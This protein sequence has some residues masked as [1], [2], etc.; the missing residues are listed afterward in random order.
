MEE[1][2]IPGLNLSWTSSNG[3]GDSRAIGLADTQTAEALQP[4]HRMLTGSVGKTFTATSMLALLDRFQISLDTPISN[5]FSA[6]PWYQNWGPEASRITIRMLLNHTSGIPDHRA[7]PLFIE[8]LN[9][10]LKQPTPNYSVYFSPEDLIG[11]N[12]D[13]G[14]DFS[15]GSGYSYTETGFIVAGLLIELLAGEPFYALVQHLFIEPLKLTNTTPA[16]WGREYKLAQG[17][18]DPKQSPFPKFTLNKGKLTINPATE[19]TGGGFISTATDLARWGGALYRGEALNAPY[20][21]PMITSCFQGD[22][23]SQYGLG[24]Y[25]WPSQFGT[26]YGHSGEA[27]GYRSIMAY[28]PSLEISLAIQINTSVPDHAI[29]NTLLETALDTIVS[30]SCPQ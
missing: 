24:C 12:D 10:T 5:W 22:P 1:Q 18:V 2:Q 13:Q 3:V 20:L 14:L 29:L 25:L 21:A 6:K 11:F 27:P 23:V 9:E 17:H 28:C 16:L 4:E 8:A 30:D 7:S 26:L 19:W 15:P